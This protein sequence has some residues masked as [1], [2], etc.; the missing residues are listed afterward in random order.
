MEPR[1]CNCVP[2]TDASYTGLG[3]GFRCYGLSFS[4]K[5]EQHSAMV[6]ET[7]LFM[8]QIY[9]LSRLELVQS[10]NFD[11]QIIESSGAL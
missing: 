2:L 8:S 11:S 6:L 10:R 7:F 4:L 5:D 9:F 3:N 1:H